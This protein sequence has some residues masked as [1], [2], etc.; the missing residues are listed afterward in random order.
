MTTVPIHLA[1]TPE[2]RYDVVVQPGAL[3]D[4]GPRIAATLGAGAH[5]SRR[6]AFMVADAGLPGSLIDA[7]RVS[8]DAAGFDA[9]VELLAPSE[10]VKTLDTA[11]HLLERIIATRHERTDPLIAIG[12]G[13]V[14]DVA[15]F[16]ASIYRRGVPV[17]QCPTTLLAMVD[18]SVGGKTGVN[19]RAGD[20]LKKNM[21]GC[22]WQPRL[23]IAD[24]GAL[25]SLPD[26][27][28]RAGL[29]ECLKHGL[30]SR[31]T[32][33]DLFSWTRAALPRVLSRDGAALAQLIE[34][35]VRVKASFV[36]GDEREEATSAEGGRAILNLGHTFGHAIE[37]IPHLSP[38]A[39]AGDAP[40]HHGE[41]VALG[42]VAAAATS[43]AL[44]MLTPADAESVRAAVDAAGLP[45]RVA[46]L[47]SDDAI[48][49]AMAHDKKVA[50]G[51]L[52]LVLLRAIGNACV[53]DD[54][55]TGAVVAGLRAIRAE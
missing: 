36:A 33:P 24:P 11:E 51:R 29:A 12:G 55:P 42:L 27:Q 38:T 17:I 5:G 52:R 26:R 2:R 34:R 45:S 22:F 16:V 46:Q 28:L 30:I 40:L 8:L 48:L 14:G 47:P 39:D 19:L 13:I 1:S 32:D 7:A 35:N 49:A 25:A 3:A 21:V 23:V 44:G 15:G 37:T 10:S 43:A 4:L 9:H 6:R 20:T 41:A 53:I 18:A 54:P 31:A 50:G